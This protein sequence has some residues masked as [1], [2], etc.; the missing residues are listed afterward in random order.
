MTITASVKKAMRGLAAED[1]LLHEAAAVAIDSCERINFNFNGIYA[2]RALL[3]K[4]RSFHRRDL[5]RHLK[6]M[7]EYPDLRDKWLGTIIRLNAEQLHRHFGRLDDLWQRMTL[8]HGIVSNAAWEVLIGYPETDPGATR[9]Q[10]N[11]ILMINAAVLNVMFKTN[12][13][14]DG[15]TTRN[16][17]TTVD[18]FGEHMWELRELTPEMTDFVLERINDVDRIVALIVKERFMQPEAL[19]YMLDGSLPMTG[20][21]HTVLANAL[22]MDIC[23]S[24]PAASE[25]RIADDKRGQFTPVQHANDNA[26]TARYA[27]TLVAGARRA[28]DSDAL[29]LHDALVPPLTDQDSS[30]YSYA[31]YSLVNALREAGHHNVTD[32]IDERV[33]ENVMNFNESISV[34]A[35]EQQ[36]S[37]HRS[38][39][40]D[41]AVD[42]YEKVLIT[43][44]ALGSEAVVNYMSDHARA[45]NLVVDRG[46][47]SHTELIAAVEDILH[48]GVLADGLL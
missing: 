30:R 36:T 16:G 34:D 26:Q 5:T 37:L 41:D 47:T 35:Y 4:L 45:M 9:E 27:L 31:L 11:A 22:T 23:S 15:V 46:F 3:T 38:S 6:R 43:A 48:H 14:E 1:K 19:S 25:R 32:I 17:Y 12:Y 28:K 44:A 8:T 13:Y 24:V 39:L 33:M 42:H 20:E 2:Y 21:E 10:T 18:Q 29:R 40:S 7:E